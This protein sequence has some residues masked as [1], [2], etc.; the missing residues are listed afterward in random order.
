MQDRWELRPERPHL[1]GSHL[2]GGPGCSFE[3]KMRG[4]AKEEETRSPPRGRLRDFTM[5]WKL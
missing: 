4:K 5:T 2:G 1:L 3:E